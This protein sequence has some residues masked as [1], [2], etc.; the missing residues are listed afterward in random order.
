M[1]AV[2]PAAS[3]RPSAERSRAAIQ[4]PSGSTRIHVTASDAETSSSEFSARRATSGAIGAPYAIERP[5]SPCAT[6]ATQL[7]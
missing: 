4:T 6:E 2:A 3:R 1:R 7:A 5:R